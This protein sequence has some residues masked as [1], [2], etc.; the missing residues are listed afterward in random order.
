MADPSEVRIEIDIDPIPPAVMQFCREIRNSPQ[1][2]LIERQLAIIC[3]Y[4]SH[5]INELLMKFEYGMAKLSNA[6]S[7]RKAG[8]YFPPKP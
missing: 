5:T 1:S 8:E 4:N 6:P 7:E 2:T 3:L